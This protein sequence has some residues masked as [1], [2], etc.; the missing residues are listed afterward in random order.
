MPSFPRTTAALL[1]LTIAGGAGAT[2]VPHSL[3]QAVHDGAALFAGGRFGSTRTYVPLNGFDRH[4][5]T[6]QACHSH[7]GIGPGRTPGGLALPSLQGAA[8]GYPKLRGGR[9]VTL[10]QQ[11]AHCIAGG[12]GGQPPRA[13]SADMT[14]LVAYLSALS[15]GRAFATQLPAP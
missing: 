2:A 3:R 9:V 6:C 4:A 8:A 7:G 15:R 14:D 13:G 1:A 5:L 11:I 10:E 12:L